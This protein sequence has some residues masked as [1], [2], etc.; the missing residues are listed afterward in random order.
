MFNKLTEKKYKEL[1]TEALISNYLAN[2][3]SGIETTPE[4]VNEFAKGFM[5]ATLSFNKIKKPSWL[6]EASYEIEGAFKELLQR[7]LPKTKKKK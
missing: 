1:L 7:E 4:S 5:G 3:V 2:K 6:V